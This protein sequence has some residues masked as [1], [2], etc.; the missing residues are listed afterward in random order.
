MPLQSKGA[1]KHQQS[2]VFENAVKVL[3]NKILHKS[4]NERETHK[5]IYQNK[6]NNKKNTSHIRHTNTTQHKVWEMKRHLNV[7][8]IFLIDLHHFLPHLDV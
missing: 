5:K 3:Q 8:P 4:S 7:A 1:E 2:Q 6:S